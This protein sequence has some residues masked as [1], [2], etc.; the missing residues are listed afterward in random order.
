MI[1]VGPSTH[2]VPNGPGLPQA[3]VRR[4]TQQTCD[5][6]EVSDLKREKP[7]K[8]RVTL[9]NSQQEGRGLSPR[10]VRT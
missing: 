1:T 7:L 6:T 9:A 10:A 4:E 3:V 2:P 8:V 5:R